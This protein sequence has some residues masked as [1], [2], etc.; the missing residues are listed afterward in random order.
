M[1]RDLLILTSRRK[2]GFL[3]VFLKEKNKLYCT[4][5]A[6]FL[7]INGTRH[8]KVESAEQLKKQKG[9]ANYPIMKDKTIRNFIKQLNSQKNSEN[10]YVQPLTSTV[11]YAHVWQN[12]LHPLSK[13]RKLDGPHAFYFIKN[14]Q[15]EYVGA[16]SMMG[17]DLH[18]V[19]LSKF[20]KQGHLTCAL[21]QVI[22]PHIFQDNRDEQRITIDQNMIG[23]KNYKASIKVARSI[24]FVETSFFDGKS[25]LKI[26][27]T[28]F[29]DAPYID[30]HY[31]NISQERLEILVE[32]AREHIKALLKIE[33]ELEMRIG[34]SDD[35][36]DIL[37]LINET[38]KIPALI[39]DA[40]WSAIARQ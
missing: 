13:V 5:R 12:H 32:S 8:S 28:Q 40:Y 39:E 21:Q 2:K 1:L 7:L 29:K 25:E 35:V 4:L 37:L 3:K 26:L 10:I 15:Q 22:L 24:G 31:S 19:I 6:K 23:A 33:S 34:F 20:R 27:R 14:A 16:V 30:G 36:E 18:W 11:D 17:S 9:Q 38:K